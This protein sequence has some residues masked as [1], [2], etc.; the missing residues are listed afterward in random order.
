MEKDIHNL[1][2]IRVEDIIEIVYGMDIDASSVLVDFEVE[3][4]GVSS[5][6]RKFLSLALCFQRF[7]CFHWRL[8]SM[9]EVTFELGQ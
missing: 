5:P 2:G 7:S 9:I 4:L 8:R 6:K 3:I 1:L